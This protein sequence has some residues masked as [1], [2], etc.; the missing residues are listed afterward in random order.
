[1]FNL[2]EQ[3]P[4]SGTLRLQ[5]EAP[6]VAP[7]HQPPRPELTPVPGP[8]SE[9][10]PARGSHDGRT[11]GRVSGKLVVAAGLA[12]LAIG[13][14]CLR[15]FPNNGHTAYMDEASQIL[16]GRY[17][18]Q[19]GT[20]YAAILNWS[21]GSYLWPLVAGSLDIL[22]GLSLVRA[23]TGLCG[24]VM[25]LAT[26][27]SAY[28]L[29]PQALPVRLRWAAGFLAGLIM[30]I[31]PS[32]LGVGNFGTYDALAGA[33][34]MSGVALLFP[35]EGRARRLRLA[36]AFGLLFGAF[37]AKYVIAIYFP[38]IC[39]YLLFSARTLKQ[40]L[41]RVIWFVGPLSAV[42]ALYFLIFRSELLTLLSFSH[43]YT[44]LKSD[45]PFLVY[46][47]ERPEIWL[48]VAA[49]SF[50]WN[51]A[52]RQ[53]KVIAG[54]GSV[55]IGA[56]QL[57][58]R[59]DFDFWKHSIYLIFFL[60][61]LAGLALAVPAARL[62]TQITPARSRA[63]RV[64]VSA[65][66]AGVVLLFG[67]SLNLTLSQAYLLVN[68]YPN[69]SAALPAIQQNVA[70]AKTVL[71]DD[72][73]LRY[74]LY[75]Q[76]PT[77]QVTDP[78][79]IDYRGKSGLEGYRLGITDRHFDVII[80]D[81]G[82]GPVGQLISKD[83]T[84]VIKQYYNPVA[85]LPG[86]NATLVQI[87]KPARCTVTPPAPG[88]KV[89]DFSAGLQGWGSRLR[90]GDFQPG[91]QVSVSQD[92]TCEGHTSLKFTPSPQVQQVGVH[93]AQPV[94]A[95][96]AQVYIEPVAGFSGDTVVGMAG[97]DQNWQWHDDGFKQVVPVGRWVEISWQ[98]PAPGIYNEADLVFPKEARVVYVSQVE[99]Q[100]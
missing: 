96:K 79:Y 2:P 60:A 16:A 81:G 82:I 10:R 52:T 59:P 42:C 17:L 95:I 74:Y 84:P 38:F 9:L 45:D 68:F 90:Q 1:V 8:A 32:A 97:F 94:K 73:A 3:K 89:F 63:R 78:F 88:S 93:L 36:A 23:F 15:F 27:I 86:P 83:L 28:R 53:N 18:I 49:A 13:A 66:A 51:Y 67:L 80:L 5:L 29:A 19:N 33:F 24:V 26:V 50:G 92:Q 20:V 62:L 30:A 39:L 54:G 91:S 58:T 77:E 98:L 55:V 85:S 21:Y 22:G 99:V 46:V 48:L 44:D 65:L 76:L 61:P 71:T 34:F 70:G 100:P 64:Q 75:P 11:G 72:V 37:L 43:N 40:S 4:E 47:W 35:V 14:F 25:T 12:A 56:F 41:G 6:P 87:Y 31:F 7:P 57:I 69:L